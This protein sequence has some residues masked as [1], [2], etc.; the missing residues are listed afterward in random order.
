MPT[1]Q[2]GTEWHVGVLGVD[3]TV[4]KHRVR[5]YKA[6]EIEVVAALMRRRVKERMEVGRAK[7]PSAVLSSLVLPVPLASTP[8]ADERRKGKQVVSSPILLISSSPTAP[9]PPLQ[10]MVE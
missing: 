3:T 7:E 4:L 8:L 10:A 2:A 9:T 5:R 1:Y 6:K